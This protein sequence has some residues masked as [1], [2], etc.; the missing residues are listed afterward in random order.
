VVLHTVCSYAEEFVTTGGDI[1]SLHGL[2]YCSDILLEEKSMTNYQK[3][4]F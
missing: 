1:I 4:H 3:H 2:K